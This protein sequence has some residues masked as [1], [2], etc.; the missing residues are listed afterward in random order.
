MA[1]IKAWRTTNDREGAAVTGF[2]QVAPATAM[3]GSRPELS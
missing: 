1:S 2:L 3:A